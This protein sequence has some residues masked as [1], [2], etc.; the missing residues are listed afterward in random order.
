M[1]ELAQELVPGSHP[2]LQ[3]GDVI[4]LKVRS[5]CEVNNGSPLTTLAPTV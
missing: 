4:L 2:T 3:A 5:N 1:K